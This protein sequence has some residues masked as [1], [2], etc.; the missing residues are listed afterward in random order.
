MPG[1]VLDDVAHVVAG[2]LARA[3][4]ALDVPALAA[5]YREQNEFLVLP[6]VVPPSLV[7]LLIGEVDRARPAIHRN[8]IPRHKKGGSVG[9]HALAADAPAIHAVYRAPAFLEFMRAVTGRALAPCPARDP[10]ACA[11]YFYTEP[12][13]HIG[14]HYDTS[15]YKGTRYTVLLGLVERSS[16]RLVC[17]LYKDDPARE[18]VELR[19]A[20]DPGT[21]VLFNGDKLWHSITPLGHGEERVSLTMEYV[22]D[23]SMSPVKRFVSDMKDA[24]AYF[25]FRAVFAPRRAA[26]S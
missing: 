9:A 16:S 8:Y 19:L 2:E 1:P 4:A 12:G 7:A 10:H 24:I 11:L 6:R 15:Y 13:D 20:T 14:F 21:L 25:G 17:Q 26:G 3:V 23:P 5:L 22:T 18:T